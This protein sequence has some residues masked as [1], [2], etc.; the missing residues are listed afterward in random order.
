L[1]SRLKL[2]LMTKSVLAALTRSAIS[3]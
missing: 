1:V 3:S 2:C